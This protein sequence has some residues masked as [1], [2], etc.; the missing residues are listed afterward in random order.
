M[1]ALTIRFAMAQV[2]LLGSRPRP[3]LI[4]VSKFLPSLLL[5]YFIPGTVFVRNLR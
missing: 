4:R 3:L 2:F 1:L 5:C